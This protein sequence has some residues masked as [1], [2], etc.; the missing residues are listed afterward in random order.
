MFV[1]TDYYQGSHTIGIRS[2]MD[3]ENAKIGSGFDSEYLEEAD[4]HP[5]GLDVI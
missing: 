2:K 3:S 4:A 5:H 1:T